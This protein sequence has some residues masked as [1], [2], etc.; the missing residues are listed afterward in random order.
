M[1]VVIESGIPDDWALQAR[2]LAERFR[3]STVADGLG[4][5]LASL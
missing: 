4:R 2:S 1:A 3:R 5:F